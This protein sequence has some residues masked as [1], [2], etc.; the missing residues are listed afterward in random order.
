MEELKVVERVRKLLALAGNNPSEK[1]AQAAMLK[2]QELM[3]QYDIDESKLKTGLD[4]EYVTLAA[5]HAN[6]EGFRSTLAVIIAKNFKCKAFLRGNII[7]FYGRKV[8]CEIC[9][10]VF[11]YA[12]KYCKNRGISLRNQYRNEGR[13]HKGVANSYFAGFMMGLKESFE[14]QSVALMV[15]VPQD[16]L[17][18]FDKTYSNCT[19]TYKGG[20]QNTP[21][22]NGLYN[23]GK[24]EGKNFL[25]HKKIEG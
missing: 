22:H 4:I 1:E 5:T 23:T 21:M 3:A 2:A 9:V 6:N 24:E 17:D 15:I 25:N 16:V 13:Y 18:T 7:H 10:Q 11:N 20:M 12:Y 8:D 19:K 14:V